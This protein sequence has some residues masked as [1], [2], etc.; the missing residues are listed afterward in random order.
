MDMVYSCKKFLKSQIIVN[1]AAKV[2]IFS[3]KSK[4]IAK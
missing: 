2:H 1:Y 4:K 3:V